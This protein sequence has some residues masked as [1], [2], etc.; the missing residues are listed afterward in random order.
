MIDPTER[1]NEFRSAVTIKL[2]HYYEISATKLDIFY[3]ESKPVIDPVVKIVNF[4]LTYV[5]LALQARFYTLFP[6]LSL[7]SFSFGF[8]CDTKARDVE[9]KVDTVFR[10]F[11][12]FWAKTFFYTTTGLITIFGFPR[13][14]IAYYIFTSM[15]W[16]AYSYRVFKKHAALNPT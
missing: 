12:T 3:L 16:G 7:I 9:K 13:T 1:L 4:F 5:D 15:Q 6:D 8:F 14:I 10:S 2:N 11:Q